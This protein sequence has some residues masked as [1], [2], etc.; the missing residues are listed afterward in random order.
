[1]DQLADPLDQVAQD[2]QEFE[3][4]SAAQ[5]S[6]SQK[7][8]RWRVAFSCIGRVVASAHRPPER[9]TLL[10][11]HNARV[12]SSTLMVAPSVC[13]SARAA[14]LFDSFLRSGRGR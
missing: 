11:D 5:L 9:V 13:A 2:G 4:A 12:T 10:K 6:R 7:A 14:L 1:M 3:I 8:S